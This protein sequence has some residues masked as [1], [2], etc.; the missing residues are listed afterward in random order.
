MMDNE[1]KHQ[2]EGKQ[3]G[4][5]DTWTEITDINHMAAVE[6]LGYKTKK[7]FQNPD[8]EQLSQAQKSIREK[9]NTT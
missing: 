8:I 2:K 4:T 6:V 7:Q 9:I 3:P 5:Q 1:Y